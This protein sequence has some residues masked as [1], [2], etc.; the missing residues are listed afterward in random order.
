MYACVYNAC[1]QLCVCSYF[2]FEL[3][4]TLP[5]YEEKD[6]PPGDGRPIAI[7]LETSEIRALTLVKDSLEDTE[8]FR[9]MTAFLKNGQLFTTVSSSAFPHCED[10]LP[11]LSYKCFP[12]L[13][14]GQGL[15]E[16]TPHSQTGV[17]MN[18]PVGSGSPWHVGCNCITVQ[19]V[20]TFKEAGLTSGTKSFI[21]DFP[22]SAW[23][24]PSVTEF[25]ESL[26]SGSEGSLTGEGSPTVT[27]LIYVSNPVS[28]EVEKKEFLSLLRL[29]DSLM[30][31]KNEILQRMIPM[32]D[33]IR[34]DVG[35]EDSEGPNVAD[36][37]YASGAVVVPGACFRMVLPPIPAGKTAGTTVE[38]AGIV[39]ESSQ[40]NVEDTHE[41]VSQVETHGEISHV[42]TRGEISHVETRG[43]VSQVETHGGTLLLDPSGVPSQE[44]TDNEPS[45]EEIGVEAWLEEPD[46]DEPLPQ[47]RGSAG[48]H[49]PPSSHKPVVVDC[50]VGDSE[51]ITFVANVN[52]IEAMFTARHKGIT[53][54]AG[55]HAVSVEEVEQR[56]QRAATPEVSPSEL[57]QV[58]QHEPVVKLRADIGDIAEGY[59]T[60]SMENTP[61][62]LVRLDINGLCL[63]LVG[64]HM[65]AIQDFVEDEIPANNPIPLD[66]VVKNT[67][68]SLL[69]SSTAGKEDLT[70]M[71]VVVGEVYV[72]R[73]PKPKS[74]YSKDVSGSVE[75]LAD[76]PFDPLPVHLETQSR[77]FT[78]V[79][80]LSVGSESEESGLKDEGI[81]ER[82]TTTQ[83]ESLLVTFRTFVEEFQSFISHPEQNL[84]S[85]TGEFMELLDGM[86][87]SLA[88]VGVSGNRYPPPDY[89]TAVQVDSESSQKILSK[90][91]HIEAENSQ[92]QEKVK[93]LESECVCKEGQIHE[94]EQALIDC[95]LELAQQKE[96]VL[97]K[98]DNLKHLITEMGRVNG[99]RQ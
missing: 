10:D 21:K 86:R 89:T 31:F 20:H 72:N 37:L 65:G 2:L 63:D 51:Q 5:I 79:T 11:F 90:L 39:S 8:H 50:L 59:F 32:R 91:G 38:G 30:Q 15:G 80:T 64:K 49:G 12:S 17:I 6:Q 98:D 99:P 44:N 19:F 88:A 97:E 52:G 55:I 74:L 26:S 40:E 84:T 87:T 48:Q 60:P 22:L 28:A 27:A 69:E 93:V 16:S 85:R 73:G 34:G 25:V 43:E 23:I 42:E 57:L 95:K 4:I 77:K 70:S 66:I 92:L 94:L 71:N 61:D 46:L 76:E 14:A 78:T 33:K 47:P 1:I 62:G 96:L 3:Q 9:D 82:G 67:K 13:L 83:D 54:K 7:Q 81:V 41:E 36:Q 56:G 75:T 45:E 18:E 58:I 24:F 35:E 53:A 29:K 68:L